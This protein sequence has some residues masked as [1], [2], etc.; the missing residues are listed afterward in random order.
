MLS[1]LT[2]WLHTYILHIHI[3]YIYILYIYIYSEF[4]LVLDLT[5][6]CLGLSNQHFEKSEH[7][8]RNGGALLMS[9]LSRLEAMVSQSHLGVGWPITFT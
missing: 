4:A 8:S 5:S 9:T 3:I 1:G 6:L 2:W 7:S